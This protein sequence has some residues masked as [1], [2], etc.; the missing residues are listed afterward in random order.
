MQLLL[1]LLLAAGLVAALV[2]KQTK[3]PPVLELRVKVLQEVTVMGL[4][5]IGTVVAAVALV[6]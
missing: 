6:P 2:V 5:V 1:F 4:L 3:H